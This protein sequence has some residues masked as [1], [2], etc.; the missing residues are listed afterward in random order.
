MFFILYIL[1]ILSFMVFIFSIYRYKRIGLIELSLPFA[2]FY[3]FFRPLNI[4]NC[5]DIVNRDLYF[6]NEHYYIF[7]VI[8]SAFAMLAYQ[9]GALLLPKNS[10]YA[11]KLRSV[12]ILKTIR[13]FN[14]LFFFSLYLFIFFWSILFFLYGMSLFPWNRFSSGSLSV[15]FPGFQFVWPFLRILIF[16]LIFLSLFLFFETKKKI[17]FFIFVLIVGSIIILG[18]RGIILTPIILFYF[19][20]INYSLIIKQESLL[21]FFNLSNF[22][23]FVLLFFIIFFGKSIGSQIVGIASQVPSGEDPVVK[24]SEISTICWANLKGFQEY[25]LLW[26]AVVNNYEKNYSLLDFVPALLGNFVSHENRL[27]NYPD[28][29]S[30]TDKLMLAHAYDSYLNSKFG[31]SP[32]SYQFYFSYLGPF[33]IFFFFLLGFLSRKFELRI[34]YLFLIGSVF[35]GYLLN[36][37][38]GILGSPIDFTLKYYIAESVYF[39]IFWFSFYLYRVSVKLFKRSL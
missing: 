34:L 5:S 22:L 11:A 29:Y 14:N 10:L 19:V 16:F 37:F 33:S 27:L 4:D 9:V 13:I 30:I 38:I 23:I 20:Y 26:P 28:L 24:Y 39:I 35:S 15:N 2:W 12:N 3:I 31:I 6:W 1:F 25:D 7:G 36:L 18:S 21:K 17:Y 32:N 8:F